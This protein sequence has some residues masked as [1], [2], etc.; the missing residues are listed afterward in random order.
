[1]FVSGKLEHRGHGSFQIGDQSR[2]NHLRGAVAIAGFELL[3]CGMDL[4]GGA[5]AELLAGARGLAPK[6]V[7]D[8]HAKRF[9]NAGDV[10]GEE[11]VLQT[12]PQGVAHRFGFLGFRI[13]GR[14]GD[15]KGLHDLGPTAV[16]FGSIGKTIVGSEK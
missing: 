5:L 11:I 7:V 15:R 8:A 4:H 6:L 9:L 16:D 1:M 13:I 3:V 10:G 2:G 14:A 12:L